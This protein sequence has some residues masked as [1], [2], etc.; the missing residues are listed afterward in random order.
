MDVAGEGAAREQAPTG[1]LVAW[2]GLWTVVGCGCSA[3]HSMPHR[4][5]G[6]LASLA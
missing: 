2:Y 3:Y 1:A 5:F 4:R 6:V